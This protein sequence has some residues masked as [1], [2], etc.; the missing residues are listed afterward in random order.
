[1]WAQQLEVLNRMGGWQDTLVSVPISEKLKSKKVKFKD[2]N[3]PRKRC[4]DLPWGSW[5]GNSG[6][7]GMRAPRLVVLNRGVGSK[8]V[9]HFLLF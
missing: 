8:A 7:G 9:F 2:T 6:V 1:M 5:D 3:F 4:K